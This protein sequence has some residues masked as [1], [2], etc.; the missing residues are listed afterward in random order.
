MAEV[1]EITD[2]NF[3]KEVINA[4]GA[5]LVEFSAEWC[6]PCKKLAPIVKEIASEMSGKLKVVYMDVEKA[7]DTAVKFAILSVPTLL[8][9]K[10][11][12]VVEEII[13]LVPKKMILEKVNKVL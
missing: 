7:R 9:F 12:R 5:T 3:E 6:G 4:N 11:G 8:I 1:L 10:G 13:G 2:E